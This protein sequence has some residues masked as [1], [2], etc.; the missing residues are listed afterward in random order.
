MEIGVSSRHGDNAIDQGKD[1]KTSGMACIHGHIKSP[2]F[3]VFFYNRVR[4]QVRKTTRTLKRQ[5]ELN[6]AN[7]GKSILGILSSASENKI[8]DG[9]TPW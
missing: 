1:K 7:D 4:N 3:R 2:E 9:T 8:R 6:I 5:Y